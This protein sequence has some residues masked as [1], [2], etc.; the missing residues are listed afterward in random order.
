MNPRQNAL[1]E[2]K[3]AAIQHLDH[4]TFFRM[5][6]EGRL[7]AV[8]DAYRDALRESLS[9]WSQRYW[10]RWIG[11]FDSPRR[12]FYFR[13]TSGSF[14]RLINAYIDHV[15]HLRAWIDAILE[16]P[17]VGHQREIYERYL[18]DR[19]WS[20]AMWFLMNQDATLSLLGVPRAQ[21]HQVESQY[22]GGVVQFIHD[23]LEAVFARLPLADNYFWRVYLTGG[24]SR[25]CCPEYLKPE[26]FGRLKAGLADRVSVHTGTVE[27]FLRGHDVSISRFVLLDH[28]DW[29]SGSLL[30]YLEAEW[31]AILQRAAPGCRVIWRSGGLQT[32][33]VNEVRVTVDGRSRR[34]SELLCYH[35]EWAARLHASCRVHTYGSFHIADVAA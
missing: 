28:M 25:S 6:G 9:P 26:N 14:A 19:F 27:G 29:L 18:H 34:L 2:L 35:P 5:F 33:F 10:D 32:A 11:V 7:Q 30:P 4:E 1:L 21:R 13:G 12:P 8:G 20:R 31:Q 3:L 17:S 23:C 22:N 16:A 15:A 24:Y